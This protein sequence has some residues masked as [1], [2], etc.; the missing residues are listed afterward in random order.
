[1]DELEDLH[2]N[3]TNILVCHYEIWGREL[4]SREANPPQVIQYWP[5]Q[6][7][8]F[9]VAFFVYYYV[10]FHFRKFFLQLFKFKIYSD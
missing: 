9:F 3:R 7:G 5:F 4:G 6:A 1:M 10:L 2:T 8:T